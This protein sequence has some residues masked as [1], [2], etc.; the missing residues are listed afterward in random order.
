MSN[1]T[2]VLCISIPTINNVYKFN[3]DSNDTHWFKSSYTSISKRKELLK[4]IAHMK[5]S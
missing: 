5:T 1:A 4:L 2:S 3:I